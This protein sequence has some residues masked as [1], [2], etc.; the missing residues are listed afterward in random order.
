MHRVGR[1]PGEQFVQS[2]RR[3]AIDELRENV[4]KPVLGTDAIELVRLCRPPNYAEPGL[5]PQISR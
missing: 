1:R 4:S 2:R 3:P 5:F